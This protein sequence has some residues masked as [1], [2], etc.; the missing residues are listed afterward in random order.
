MAI[1]KV[2][3][4]SKK[5]TGKPAAGYSPNTAHA[6]CTVYPTFSNIMMVTMETIEENME[7]LAGIVTKEKNPLGENA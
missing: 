1:Q 4:K 5:T 3:K 2:P 6:P 7:I